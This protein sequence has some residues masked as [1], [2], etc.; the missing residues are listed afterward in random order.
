MFLLSSLLFIPP[1]G[2]RHRALC[3]A[4]QDSALH[5]QEHGAD[6]MAPVPGHLA[7][8]STG[9]PTGSSGGRCRDRC[10]ENSMVGSD[11]VPFGHLHPSGIVIKCSKAARRQ[12]E[13]SNLN[14]KCCVILP[15]VFNTHLPLIYSQLWHS[16]PWPCSGPTLPPSQKHSWAKQPVVLKGSLTAGINQQKRVLN[17]S[18]RSTKIPL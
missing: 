6:F 10:R 9:N 12:L 14:A 1:S 3:S 16:T 8:C 13:E 11:P 7:L 5:W 4:F 17:N 2:G 18:F 15:K